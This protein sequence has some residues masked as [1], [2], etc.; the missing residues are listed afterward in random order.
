MSPMSAENRCGWP[1]RWTRFLTGCVLILAIV[2]Q[3]V[4]AATHVLL[5]GVNEYRDPGIRNLNGAVNDVQNLY[6]VFVREFAIP[7]QN[8]IVLLDREA[9][10]ERVDDA[11]KNITKNA[12]LEDTVIVHFSGHGATLPD[13]DGD[14]SRQADKDAVDEVLCLHD[15]VRKSGKNALRDDVLG[16]YLSSFEAGEVVVILDCCHSGTGTKSLGDLETS[17]REDS[18]AERLPGFRVRCTHLGNVA[19]PDDDNASRTRGLRA[20]SPILNQRSLSRSLSR[21]LNSKSRIVM[22]ACLATQKA[23]E[24]HHRDVLRNFYSGSLTHFLV[25]GL[26]G[27]ADRNDDGTVTYRE[28][29]GYTRERLRELQNSGGFPKQTPVLEISGTS[30]TRPVFS[31]ADKRP[32]HAI[33]A[34]DGSRTVTIDLGAVHGIR[35]GQT[36]GVYKTVEDARFVDRSIGRFKVSGIELLRATGQVAGGAALPAGAVLAPSVEPAM[37]I[38][39]STEKNLAPLPMTVASDLSTRINSAI[40]DP[41]VRLFSGDSFDIRIEVGV[42]IRDA[43]DMDVRLLYFDCNGRL[44]KREVQRITEPLNSERRRMLTQPIRSQLRE[45]LPQARLRRFAQIVKPVQ[46]AGLQLIVSES[47]YSIGED[48]Q[49]AMKSNSA[50]WYHLIAIGPDGDHV[51]LTADPIPLEKGSTDF[52]PD[53]DVNQQ[54]PRVA[55]RWEIRMVAAPAELPAISSRS[56]LPLQA[57]QNARRGGVTSICFK[58]LAKNR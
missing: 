41:S 10:R 5:I 35:P 34:T 6:E 20:K 23:T 38:Q 57:V 39:V 13:D 12:K 7:K 1:F 49:L 42:T 16:K 52:F 43:E 22:T 37:F 29:Y 11:F 45:L 55:G 31:S 15:T 26:R 53:R 17:K 33:A 25:E 9:T 2:S 44:L 3:P 51:P 36:L 54:V 50:C 48:Y 21:S 4:C 18:D 32:L 30:A 28:A 19:D 27:A 40:A 58:V 24:L 47:T 8:I 46:N 14:E 56:P